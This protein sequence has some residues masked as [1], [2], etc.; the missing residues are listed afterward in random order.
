MNLEK[1][2]ITTGLGVAGFLVARRFLSAHR[3]VIDKDTPVTPDTQPVRHQ[4]KPVPD[5]EP[6]T[7]AD[8]SPDKGGSW[9]DEYGGI[10]YFRTPPDRT[11][12]S[13]GW[14]LLS[15]G[16]EYTALPLIDS[17]IYTP[18]SLG[19]ARL[20]Y[21]DAKAAAA[22]HG[23]RL[24]TPEE[25]AQIWKEGARIHVH[26]LVRTNY[27]ENHM[28]SLRYA[29]RYDADVAKQLKD[30]DGATPVANAGK[31]WVDGA[32][33]GRAYLMGWWADAKN[34]V[35]DS[36][37]PIQPPPPPK[38]PGPHDANWHDYGTLTYVVRE[39]AVV[40]PHIPSLSPTW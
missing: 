10:R 8:L 17:A 36:A 26:G 20:T 38:S 23:G 2:L 14:K 31:W 30:W 28:R 16:L 12:V 5:V 34:D 11:S 37:K 19:F 21:P 13:H 24:P 33:S 9:S 32:P 27:D 18:D 25:A 1:I 6:K 15:N 35:S 40:V 29:R 4:E 7:F 3:T 39:P 22:R